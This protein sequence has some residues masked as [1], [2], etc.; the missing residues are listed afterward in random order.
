MMKIAA[1]LA[2]SV[3]L[4][5][6]GAAL[7]AIADDA[8]DTAVG[9]VEQTLG[10]VPTFMMQMPKA[11]FAGAWQQ[12]RD[13]EFSEDTALSQKEKA[14]I[15]L[16]VNAQIPCTYCTWAATEFA[17]AS[18]ATNEEIG[19]AIAIAATERYWSTMLN[20]L[21]ADIDVFKAEFG[22]LFGE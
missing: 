20:G 7:P 4:L 14:L 13:L 12:L 1:T 19:E 5:F 22:P 6:G 10:F 11:G 16:G 21:Q 3:A 17:R 18:G 8:Y 15:A 9:N 2:A